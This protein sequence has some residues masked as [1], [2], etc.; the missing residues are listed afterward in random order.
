MSVKEISTCGVSVSADRTQVT[1][2]LGDAGGE[3]ALE[4]ELPRDLAQHLAGTIQKLAARRRPGPAACARGA[5]GPWRSGCAISTPR[6][7]C[8]RSPASPA[9]AAA[10]TGSRP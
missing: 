7:A 3:K 4:V 8:S 9:S 1:L 5:R 10:A 6:P 2:Y